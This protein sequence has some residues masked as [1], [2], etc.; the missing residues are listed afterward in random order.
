[1]A[2]MGAVT[3]RLEFHTAVLKL[4]VRQTMIL[5][6]QLTSLAAVTGGRIVL[7]VG[8]SPWPEDYAAT[9]VPWEGRGRRMDEM[10]VALRALMTGDYAAFDGEHVRFPSLK[11]DPVPE[12]PVPLLVGGHSRHALER[13]ARLGDGWVSVG[14]TSEEL[15]DAVRRIETRR[16]ELGREAAEPTYVAAGRGTRDPAGVQAFAD[17]GATH[18]IADFSSRRVYEPHASPQSLEQT[19]AE[20]ADYAERVILRT[21]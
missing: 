1:M 16:S 20:L 14:S 13:V 3:T 12:R 2:T 7:G 5:A 21:G 17:A 19:V 18:V 10:M 11:L 4:P 15:A 9:G 6:K 8:L